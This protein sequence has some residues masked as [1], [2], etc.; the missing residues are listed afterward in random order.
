MKKDTEKNKKI[1]VFI[2]AILFFYSTI[3]CNAQYSNYY[4]LNVKSR[5]DVDVNVGG[6]V[7]VNEHKTITTIDYGALQLANAQREALNFDK[8]KYT[9]DR[10]RRINLE[11][12]SNP[13]MAYDYGHDI[14]VTFKGEDAASRNFK[15]FTIKYRIPHSSLFVLAGA[16]RYENVSLDGV[17]TEIVIIGCVYNSDD[18]KIDMEKGAKMEEIKVGELN[19][20]KRFVHKKDIDRATVFGVNGFKSSVFWEDDYQYTISDIYASFD[21]Q[22]G[23][24]ITY[25]V[26]VKTYGSKKEVTFEQ[27]EGRRYYLRQLIEKIVSTA[28]IYDYKY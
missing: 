5:S 9:D 24:G 13:V 1:E 27:L 19:D 15:K 28:F 21:N 2:I 14:N 6:T 11:I 7:N 20:L 25:S 4:N 16:G 17:K 23:N 12:A 8:I 10:E 26:K 22:V 3:D 18:V